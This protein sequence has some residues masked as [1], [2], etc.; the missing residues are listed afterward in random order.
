MKVDLRV[1][2]DGRAGDMGNT[3][4]TFSADKVVG[5]GITELNDVELY[6]RKLIAGSTIFSWP[7]IVADLAGPAT[8]KTRYG[9]FRN[10]MISIFGLTTSIPVSLKSFD[11]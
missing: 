5:D 4:A 10:T 9:N 6:G 11:Q 1:V 8:S 3:S 2:R 7:S